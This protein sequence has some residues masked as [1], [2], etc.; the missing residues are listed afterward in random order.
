MH[1]TIKRYIY[2][3]TGAVVISACSMTKGVPDDD[4][5]FIG[6][7]KINYTDYEENDNYSATREEIDAALATAPNGAILG[8]SYH[9]L[10]F[11]FGLSVWNAFSADSSGLGHWMNKT[12]GKQPVLMSWVNPQLRAQVAKSVLR[13]HGYFHGNVDAEVVLQNNMKTAKI[14]YDVSFGHLFTL[15]SVRYVGFNREADSLI[16]ATSASAIVRKGDPFVVANLDGERSRISNL[17]RNNGYY[18]YQPSY[19]SYLADTFAVDGKVQLR[20]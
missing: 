18:Y 20:F 16:H 10:P 19:A 8:S 5:L 3:L 12:F 7:T 13:N 14:G 4:Q 6:L 15:D 9:R 1:S 2:L 11:S 17:L